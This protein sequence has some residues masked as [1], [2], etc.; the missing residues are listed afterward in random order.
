MLTLLYQWN[1]KKCVFLNLVCVWCVCD[2]W[3]VCSTVYPLRSEHNFW[4]SV[5]LFCLIKEDFLFFSAA[6]LLTPGYLAY[7]LLGNF[8]VSVSHF[9]VGVLGLHMWAA[10]VAFHIGYGDEVRS[11]SLDSSCFYPMS[12]LYS[13]NNCNFSTLF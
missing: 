5:L 6:E 10:Q 9:A 4:K 11:S 12:H 7:E 1:F 2:C 13:P 8:H 3:H